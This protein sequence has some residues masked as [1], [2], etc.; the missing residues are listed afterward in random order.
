MNHRQLQV[1]VVV[2]AAALGILATTGLTAAQAGA[3]TPTAPS[4][5]TPAAPALDGAASGGAVVV[6]LRSQHADLNLRTRGA[7]R[8]AA[9]RKD[10]ASLVADIKSHGG[11]GILQLTAPSAV[12]ATVSATEVARLRKDPLVK[13][14]VPDGTV[15]V[16]TGAVTTNMA[17]PADLSTKLCPTDPS[18]P[19]HEPEALSDVHASSDDP[20]AADEANDIAT[21]DG[22][23]VANDGI[24]R[25]CA[26]NPNF[27]RRRRRRARRPR[28]TPDDTADNSDGEYYGDAS[29][30]AAQGTVVYEYSKELPF[31]GLPDGCT[32]R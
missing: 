14:I 16:S 18:K 3:A 15:V 19:L 7:D 30:I 31:S 2:T 9:A 1:G 24:R 5:S 27:I 11:T 29:S 28:R 10:Q 8:R 12:A 25:R 17:P 23:I 21:G 20:T 13:K 22:V 6:W 4:S 32:S 26:G